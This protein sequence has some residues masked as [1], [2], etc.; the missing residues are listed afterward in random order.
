MLDLLFI[1]LAIVLFEV[2]AGYV[3]ACERL[4]RSNDTTTSAGTRSGR[5]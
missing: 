4:T 1:L 2:S 5:S 3:G